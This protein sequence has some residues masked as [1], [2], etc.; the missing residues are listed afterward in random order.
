MKTQTRAQI[1]KIIEKSGKIW[2]FELQKSLSISAQAIHL[3][4]L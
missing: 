1:L 2:P 4:P 3:Q